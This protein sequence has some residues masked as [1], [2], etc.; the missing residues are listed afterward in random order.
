MFFAPSK[1]YSSWQ[2]GLGQTA[3][4]GVSC[5]VLSENGNILKREGFNEN[6]CMPMAS[7]MKI[8]IALFVLKNVFAE[9]KLRLEQE[10]ELV[11]SDFCPGNPWNTLDYYYFIPWQTSAKKTLAELL[12]IM[13]QE[14]DNTASDKLLSL[15]GGPSA[16]NHFMHDLGFTDFHL[17]STLKV[18]LSD[19]YGINTDKTLFNIFTT[20]KEFFTAFTIRPT[21]NTLFAQ[22]HDVCTPACMSELL[23]MLVHNAQQDCDTWLVK[24]A[25]WIYQ[26]MEGCR[27]GLALIRKGA[28]AYQDKIGRIGDKSGSLGGIMNDTAFIEFNNKSWLIISIFTNLSPLEKQAREAI[29]AGLTADLLER[30]INYFQSESNLPCNS[31]TAPSLC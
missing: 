11:N 2:T 29:I 19:Y 7:I 8:A 22:N 6:I 5:L 13:L 26:A 9:N 17:N 23:R 3:R 16:V 14:S 1:N 20:C 25:K 21:E 18:L 27:T 31:D 30:N 15:V 28:D 24:A 4:L 10:I 12:T